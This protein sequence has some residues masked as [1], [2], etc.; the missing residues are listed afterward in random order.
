VTETRAKAATGLRRLSAGRSDTGR[1]TMEAALVPVV[2][3]LLATAR[4]RAVTQ[5]AEA[6]ED[7]RTELAEHRAAAER[8]VAEARADG[9]RAAQ[10]RAAAQ[11]ATARRQAEEMILAARRRAYE[12]LRREAVEALVRQG[13]TAEGR[14]LGRRLVA[15]VQD[16]VGASMPVHQVGPGGLTAVAESG[17]RR[18]TLGPPALVDQVL[19]SLADEIEALWA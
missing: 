16:R 9:T 5:R 4:A 12:T 8:L 19:G 7:A 6:D 18:A 1:A 2:D 3:A 10:Q 17:N 15:L 14:L 13:G 11:L